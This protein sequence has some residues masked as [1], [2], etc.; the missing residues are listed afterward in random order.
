MEVRFIFEIKYMLNI[1]SNK[2]KPVMRKE[3]SL[4]NDYITEKCTK[5]HTVYIKDCTITMKKVLLPVKV[6][7]CLKKT[8]Y[9]VGQC[10]DGVIERCSIR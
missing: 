3:D 1:K 2:F 6:K 4:C 8:R 7:R 9:R 10:V 5:C